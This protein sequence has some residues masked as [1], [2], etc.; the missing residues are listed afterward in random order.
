MLELVSSIRIRSTGT[1]DD[2]KNAD[3]LLDAVFED[4]EVPA[5]QIRHEVAAVPSGT[6]TFSATRLAPLRKTASG[7]DRPLRLGA[8]APSRR[9]RRAER[10]QDDR[11]NAGAA[12]ASSCRRSR[13][14]RC[15]RHGL[16][17]A[18]A[19]P[20]VRGP[21]GY[22]RTHVRNGNDAQI[23][24][25]GRQISEARRL[26]EVRVVARAELLPRVGVAL[27]AEMLERVGRRHAASRRAGLV[28]RAAGQPL[29]EARPGTRRRRRS[30][31]RC[32]AAARPGRPYGRPPRGS[33]S[34]ARR[35][36]RRA[37]EYA[38]GSPASSRPVFC[39]ISSNS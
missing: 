2:S 27:P 21:N 24:A 11:E 1:C 25:V 9:E 39:R 37:P 29:E 22:V 17:A 26:A 36:S 14:K 34:R 3:L 10:A 15:S 19:A 7:A 31:R 23:A 38:P 8:A 30:D 32:G 28:A 35:A 20:S 4:G 33:S 13:C 12:R 18:P 16:P 6:L 5:R